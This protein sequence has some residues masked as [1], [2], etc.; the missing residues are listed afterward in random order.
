MRSRK[1][2]SAR[3]QSSITSDGA[4]LEVLRGDAAQTRDRALETI[5]LFA[6]D[7]DVFLVEE[8]G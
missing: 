2:T 3:P 1:S 5:D 7:L 8:R 4:P 6:A